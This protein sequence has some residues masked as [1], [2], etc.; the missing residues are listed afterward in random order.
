M[1]PQQAVT[2]GARDTVLIVNEQGGMEPRVVTVAGQQGGN[3][4]LTGGLQEGDRVIV[5][6]TMIA[7]MMGAQKV[8]TREWQPG[9]GAAEPGQGA[10]AG[11]APA[12]SAAPA[13]ASAAPAASAA[14]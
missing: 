14:Q 9:E 5:A 7:G 4:I 13:A 6:G 12:A 2:R 3:W 10:P 8:Q 11:A 1:V